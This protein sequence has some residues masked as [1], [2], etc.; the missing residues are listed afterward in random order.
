MDANATGMRFGSKPTR[1]A[2][3]PNKSVPPNSKINL[4]SHKFERMEKATI[5]ARVKSRQKLGKINEI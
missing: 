2:F 5:E 4:E 1:R 3:S